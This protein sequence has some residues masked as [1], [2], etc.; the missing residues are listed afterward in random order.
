ME[1]VLLL[2]A[3]EKYL[4]G[5]M[6]AEEKNYFDALRKST[7]EVDQ[8]VVEHS[9]FL[10]QINAYSECKN[11]QAALHNAHNNLLAVG[12][13][14]ESNTNNTQATIIQLFRKYKKVTAIAASIACA[15]ALM[16]SAIM[17]LVNPP[18]SSQRIEQ[19]GMEVAKLKRNQQVQS[20]QIKAVA[21]PKLPT[22]AVITGGGTAFLI[23]GKGYLV[24]N[25]HVVKKSTKATIINANGEEFIANVILVDELKDLAIL[26]VNDKDF[27]PTSTLPY[28]IKKS[29]AL[30]GEEIYTLGFPRNEIVYNMGYLSAKT[31]LD[32][33]TTACQVSL[34]ANPGN[35]GGPVFN[36]NGEVVGVISKRQTQA[37]GVVFAIRSSNIYDMLD[38]TS[39]SDTAIAKIK[40]SNTNKS[41]KGL[42]RTKQIQKLENF[43]FLVKAYN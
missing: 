30:L 6:Q 17:Y 25:A 29:A 38:A 1:D 10:Q 28:S 41:I 11:L 7:P 15:T 3:V 18:A 20:A 8:L 35:S 4:N 36:N 16:I 37:E 33:D 40:I 39:T 12:D 31:G 13:I 27:K 42:E 2:E 24:T 43:V 5:E 22:D 21:E 14:T 23:D 9:L 32:G 19:L 34:S 26:K